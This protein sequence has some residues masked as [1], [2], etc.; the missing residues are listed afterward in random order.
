MESRRALREVSALSCPP[1][2]AP[3]SRALFQQ[4]H[5][6]PDVAAGAEKERA[7][8]RLGTMGVVKLF[9][10]INQQHRKFAPV[11]ARPDLEKPGFR[12]VSE[13]SFLDLLASGST[14]KKAGVE[15]FSRA[16]VGAPVAKAPW[17]DDLYAE[18]NDQGNDDDLGDVRAKL[19][20]E[21]RVQN[22][23]SG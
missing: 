7:L 18:G 19:E 10:A 15:H 9:N 8:R 17:L 23:S 3:F 22:E 12:A 20:E 6:K 4:W 11:T 5:V 16:R 14:A 21:E 13:A 1:T 2:T